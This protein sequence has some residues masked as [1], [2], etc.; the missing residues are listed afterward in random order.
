MYIKL[1]IGDVRDAD[2]AVVQVEEAYRIDVDIEGRY[3]MATG[4]GEVEG[5]R[6]R[7]REGRGERLVIG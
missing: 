3:I 2:G 6:G 1:Q 4:E 7:G 5:E